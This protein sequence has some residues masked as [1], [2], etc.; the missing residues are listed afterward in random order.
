MAQVDDQAKENDLLLEKIKAMATTAAAEPSCI[1]AEEGRAPSHPEGDRRARQARV[2]YARQVRQRPG[3]GAVCGQGP[4][5]WHSGRSVDATRVR[6]W[7]R[8]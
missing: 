1:N 2:R 5:L 6:G 7:V 8:G 4:D 3:R